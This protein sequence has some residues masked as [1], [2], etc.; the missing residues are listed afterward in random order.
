MGNCKTGYT[1]RAAE[2]HLQG[3]VLSAGTKHLLT[4][5]HTQRHLM[6][7]NSQLSKT[8]G[9]LTSNDIQFCSRTCLFFRRL[10]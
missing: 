2:S 7:S 5:V 1:E 4:E 8:R 6:G 9:H 10:Y 3:V